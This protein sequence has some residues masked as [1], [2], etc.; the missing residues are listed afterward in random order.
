LGLVDLPFLFSLCYVVDIVINVLFLDVRTRALAGKFIQSFYPQLAK[1]TFF[2][3]CKM[4]RYQIVTKT[5]HV[6]LLSGNVK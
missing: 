1:M 3:R 2:F 5:T 6:N 4:F